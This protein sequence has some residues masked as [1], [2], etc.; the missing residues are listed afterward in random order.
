MSEPLAWRDE[1]R[2]LGDLVPQSDNPRGIGEQQGR[3]LS[4]EPR[5]VSQAPA[6]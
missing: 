3:R 2:R 1:T 4:L 5:R 6:P